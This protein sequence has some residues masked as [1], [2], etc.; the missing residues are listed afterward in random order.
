MAVVERML[1]ILE[2]HRRNFAY[3]AESPFFQPSQIWRV[4]LFRMP[5]GKRDEQWLSRRDWAQQALSDL[6]RKARHVY[7]MM[8]EASGVSQK[9][10]EPQLAMMKQGISPKFYSGA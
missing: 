6:W 2:L 5:T 4:Q 9:L 3:L 7:Q 8:L 10:I 1:S